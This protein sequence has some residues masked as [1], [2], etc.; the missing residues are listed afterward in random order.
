LVAEASVVPVV[1]PAVSTR[2]EVVVDAGCDIPMG[3]LGCGIGRSTDPVPVCLVEVTT[4]AAALVLGSAPPALT[5]KFPE[6]VAAESIE[7]PPLVELADTQGF[8]VIPPVVYIVLDLEVAS[9]APSVIPSGAASAFIHS[10][11]I[12][13]DDSTLVMSGLPPESGYNVT[14]RSAPSPTGRSGRVT[15]PTEV[16]LRTNGWSKSEV[17]PRFIH[18]KP[19]AEPLGV[20]T[21]VPW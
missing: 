16:P 8:C 18:E 15:R 12:I 4:L 1:P 13:V 10:L 17:F 3:R 20:S 6:V 14:R 9:G 19:P 5:M 21:W 2:L 11:G 7:L